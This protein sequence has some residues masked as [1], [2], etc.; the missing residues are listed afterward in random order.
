V[1]TGVGATVGAGVTIGFGV[2]VA[3]G[4]GFGVGGTVGGGE[5]VGFG[6][7]TGGRVG[8]TGPDSE[9]MLGGGVTTT[10]GVLLALES[11]VATFPACRTIAPAGGVSPG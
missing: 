3:T 6:V 4:V 10:A 8:A 2:A 7:P 9:S 11:V 1:A 5:T